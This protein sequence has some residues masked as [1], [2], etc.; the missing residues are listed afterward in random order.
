MTEIFTVGRIDHEEIE[1]SAINEHLRCVITKQEN[2][3]LEMQQKYNVLS[4]RTGNFKA[5]WDREKQKNNALKNRIA[6]LE[7]QLALAR[8]LLS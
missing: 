3:I 6:E 1:D 5:N 4:T 2:T 8:S 7:L